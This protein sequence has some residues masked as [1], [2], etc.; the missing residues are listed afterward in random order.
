MT[1]SYKQTSIIILLSLVILSFSITTNIQNII[2]QDTGFSITNTNINK[3]K[4]NNSDISNSNSNLSNLLTF[5][6]SG[7]LRSIIIPD[8]DPDIP[9]LTYGY[10]NSSVSNGNL[11]DF[12]ANFTMARINGSET[13]TMQLVN[14][15]PSDSVSLK[16]N[17]TG[18]DLFFTGKFDV[19]ANNQLKWQDVDAVIFIDNFNTI[20]IG[21][22]S[23]KTD[24]HLYGQPIT[25][26]V[27]S[28]KDP[29]GKELLLIV[30]NPPTIIV[31][32]LPANSTDTIRNNVN[33][34]QQTIK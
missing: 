9:Y 23:R 4:S 7:F 5:T 19:K 2:A 33:M 15:K 8:K 16:G 32:A 24:N 17:T 12:N 10:W 22:D 34:T 11:T 27:E 29:G 26:I 20:S 13:H 25:G 14:F 1:N 30:L 18:V 3:T 6:A 21:L 31:P 28:I